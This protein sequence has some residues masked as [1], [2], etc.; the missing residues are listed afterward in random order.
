MSWILACV[1][2]CAVPACADTSLLVEP[3][4]LKQSLGRVRMVDLRPAEEYNKAHI[5]GAVYCSLRSLDQLEANR[6]GL[7]ISPE[8]ARD[9]F[10]QLG[11][12]PDTRVVAYDDEGGRPA[13]RFFYVAEFFGH[14]HVRVLNGGWTAW[15]EAGGDRETEARAVAPGTFQPRVNGKRMA[16]AE[17]VRERLGLEKKKLMVLDARS[18]EEYA[19]KTAPAGRPGGRIPGAVHL[20]WRDTTTANGRG[21]FKSPE[22]LRRLLVDRGFDPGCEAV[23]YC[24]SGTRSAHLYFILRLLGHSRVRNYDGSWEDWSARAGYP[25]EK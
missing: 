23:T 13:A 17:W 18:P 10:R 24:Q 12:N 6:R 4:E 11:I 1:V 15:L 20:D 7:P 3:A 25:T 14:K 9:L 8:Q 2:V 19:G 5:P 16:T 22:E 21:R